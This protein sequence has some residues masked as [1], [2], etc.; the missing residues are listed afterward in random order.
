ME[1]VA[2]PVVF[3]SPSL[4]SQLCIAAARH[5]VM[6]VVL[7][8]RCLLPIHLCDSWPV[9]AADAQSAWSTGNSDSPGSLCG[10]LQWSAR[11]VST[12]A[13]QSVP[14]CP[15]ST[16]RLL[17]QSLGSLEIDNARSSS[18]IIIDMDILNAI[19]Q[20]EWPWRWTQAASDAELRS[21]SLIKSY[22]A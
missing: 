13:V 19:I 8:M 11:R 21:W 3:F 2:L 17:S 20:P 14:F 4:W 15:L 18:L 7:L 9:G 1:E 16:H 5:S 6:N 10:A 12:G 22:S